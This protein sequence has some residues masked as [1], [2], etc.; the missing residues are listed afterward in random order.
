MAE[1]GPEATSQAQTPDQRAWARL[2]ATRRRNPV[3]LAELELRLWGSILTPDLDAKSVLT[4]LQRVGDERLTPQWRQVKSYVDGDDSRSEASA[5]WGARYAAIDEFS[6][7]RFYSLDQAK[8]TN[9]LHEGV[10][11]RAVERQLDLLRGTG[12][13][14]GGDLGEPLQRSH[15]GVAHAHRRA[16]RRAREVHG[17]ID[18]ANAL[19]DES[20]RAARAWQRR[21]ALR[22]AAGPARD[23]SRPADRL[24]PVRQAWAR[25]QRIRQRSAK[26][27]P[28]V[29]DERVL[30]AER[31]LKLARVDLWKGSAYM[32]PAVPMMAI[33]LIP[34]PPLPQILFGFPGWAIAEAAGDR[35][36]AGT[37]NARAAKQEL[38]RLRQEHRRVPPD[39]DRVAGELRRK[40]R[41]E[42]AM[43]VDRAE[44]EQ[45]DGGWQRWRDLHDPRVLAGV[46][47]RWQGWASLG[48]DERATV[49]DRLAQVQTWQDPKY[50]RAIREADYEIELFG[51]WRSYQ[52]H[53][54][55]TLHA[56]RERSHGWAGLDGNARR[57]VDV[58]TAVRQAD[59]EIQRYGQW[60]SYQ[61][62]D[63]GTLRA[64]MARSPAWARLDARAKH[65][66]ERHVEALEQR[67]EE[68]KR[69]KEVKAPHGRLQRTRDALKGIKGLWRGDGR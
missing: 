51:R 65:P 30:A 47:A 56:V 45:R 16:L 10:Q 35:I 5:I 12:D 3:R 25:L 54:L 38:H 26:R 20:S 63:L 61:A 67:Q 11:L 58:H 22:P 18:R 27:R 41:A 21:R 44:L 66:V 69:A 29:V 7:A 15:E 50:G 40:Q 14:T 19:V 6:V 36:S 17:D 53:D 23:G 43:E 24:R 31:A 60:R 37:R 46:I 55:D 49:L 52:T 48:D 8:E 33:G 64:V 4:A 68:A 57:P 42:V 1:S 59:D 2:V 9:R 28:A 13:G 62:H 32:V 34:A 39:V